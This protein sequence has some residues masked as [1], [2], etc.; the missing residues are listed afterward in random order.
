MTLWIGR[1]AAI[2]MLLSLLGF[3]VYGGV[4]FVQEHWGCE[5]VEHR[6]RSE[7][8]WRDWAQG[9]TGR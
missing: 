1:A 7:R 2:A 6:Q 4:T 8:L 3:L 5:R 9:D